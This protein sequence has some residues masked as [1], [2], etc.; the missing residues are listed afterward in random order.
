MGLE[1]FLV[2][3]ASGTCFVEVGASERQLSIIGTIL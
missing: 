3:M 1:G 2:Q